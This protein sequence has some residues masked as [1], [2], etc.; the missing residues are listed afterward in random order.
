[1]IIIIII[2]IIRFCCYQVCV[3]YS[4]IPPENRD[5]RG[6]S[7]KE[8]WEMRSYVVH[9]L[10]FPWRQQDQDALC[11]FSSLTE[12]LN[13]WMCFC[14]NTHTQAPCCFLRGSTQKHEHQCLIREIKSEHVAVHPTDSV[15]IILNLQPLVGVKVRAAGFGFSEAELEL[16][17][18]TANLQSHCSFSLISPD[19]CF[20]TAGSAD[21]AV[22]IWNVSTGN[23]ETRL[24]DKHR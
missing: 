13:I 9:F 6:E 1:M 7:V 24:P 18:K 5:K 21:G 11:L 2:I 22:Y 8:E 16:Q 3:S 14:W 4:N 10:Q 12:T 19:G 17:V 15:T 20:L 23:L